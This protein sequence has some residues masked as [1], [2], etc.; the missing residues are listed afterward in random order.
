MVGVFSGMLVQS[1]KHSRSFVWW[2]NKAVRNHLQRTNNSVWSN[3]RIEHCFCAG[4]IE[5]TSIWS[6][7]S[8]QVYSKFMYCVRWE[9]GKETLWSQTL[10]KWRRWTHLNSTPEGSMSTSQRSG[11]FIFPFA[12]GKVQ[13]FGWEQRLRTSTFTRE[14]LE[15]GEEQEILQ[16][17]SDEWVCSIP[18][19]RRLNPWWW[20]RWKM[21]SGRSQE[22]FIYRHHVE[23]RVKLYVPR[24]ES[25]TYSVE[26][27]RRCQNNIYI[28]GRI[29]GENIEDYWKCGWRMK[30]MRCMD[31]IHKICS[32]KRKA[33]RRIHLLRGETSKKTINF[34]S[35]RY[36]ARYVQ[37]Y[38]WCSEK[39][40]QNKSGPSRNQR[41]TMPDNWEECTSSNQM[42][43]SSST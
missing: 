21:I 30:I 12:D 11:N 1:A 20:R 38:V 39:R 27:H 6:Q 40:K 23:P 36:M 24:E 22:K 19:S 7:K 15:R 4:H 34:S 14:R 31:R 41:S 28:S 37:A 32:I 33:T 26:V 10:K 43:K 2:E 25:F 16:G 3:G 42:M 35:R 18:S 5:I 17:S 9:S 8:C 13:I 29:G